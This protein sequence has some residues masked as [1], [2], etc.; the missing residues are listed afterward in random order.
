[1]KAQRDILNEHVN[2]IETNMKK[3]L[4][5]DFCKSIVNISAT[6]AEFLGAPNRNATLPI[7]KKEL[8]KRI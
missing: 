5:P 3:L 4:V 7:L 2:K 8:C 6:L 1:M